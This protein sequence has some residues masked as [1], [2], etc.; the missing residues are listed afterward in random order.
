MESS[1]DVN[2]ILWER[3]SNAAQRPQIESIWGASR[4]PVE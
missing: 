4:P 1:V 3:F 2:G